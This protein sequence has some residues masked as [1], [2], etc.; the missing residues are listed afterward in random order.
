M[1]DNTIKNNIKS[2]LSLYISIIIISFSFAVCLLLNFF[3]WN[4]YVLQIQHSVQGNS[5]FINMHIKNTEQKCRQLANQSD[6]FEDF[7]TDYGESTTQKVYALNRIDNYFSQ[8]TNSY[9]ANPMDIKIYHNNYSMYQSSHSLYMSDMPADLKE[10]TYNISP[11][12]FLWFTDSA[13]SYFCHKIENPKS[14]I[15]LYVVCTVKNSDLSALINSPSELMPKI[16]ISQT[17]E[18]KPQYSVTY[19]RLINGQNLVVYTNIYT[20]YMSLLKYLLAAILADFVLILFINKLSEITTTRLT[21][22]LYNFIDWIKSEKLYQKASEINISESDELYPVFKC[23]QSMIDEINLSHSESEKLKSRIMDLQLKNAQAQ[24]N[25]HLL[26]NSL[27]VLKWE[28]MQY[29]KDIA[30][31]VDILANYYRKSINNNPEHYTFA[32]ELELV[33]QYV[34]TISIIH[35]F[36][37]KC[38]IDFD[39]RLLNLDTIQHIFQP[40]V[41]NAILHGINHKENGVINIVCRLMD[42]GKISIVI[43]DNG[44][45][46]NAETLKNLQNYD[47]SKNKG[48]G[49][50][51]TFMRIKLYYKESSIKINSRPNHGTQF[52]IILS[53]YTK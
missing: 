1:A 21:R 23:I 53:S 19:A 16:S 25:P 49:L 27:S 43:S 5:D 8:I 10:F 34:R 38:V 45:G 48:Y 37:Y 28:C 26:Y 17:A 7:F 30:N 50:K 29:S 36:D 12:D 9:N 18:K 44:Y 31:K 24:I 42:D 39:D 20:K 35:S 32:D 51:N 47:S 13:S 4:K 41:E 40:I 3:Q 15:T 14:Q 11:N 2:T 46:M 22:Q 6:I 52:N 33:R